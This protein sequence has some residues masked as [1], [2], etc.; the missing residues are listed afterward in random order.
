L[1]I[2]NAGIL[3]KIYKTIAESILAIVIPV[4]FLLS[5]WQVNILLVL[6]EAPQSYDSSFEHPFARRYIIFYE[7]GVSFY[8]HIQTTIVKV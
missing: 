7:R 8:E 3:R 1:S 6:L 2:V 4:L 5:F